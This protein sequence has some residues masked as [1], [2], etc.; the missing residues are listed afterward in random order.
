MYG[1]TTR[2]TDDAT[3]KFPDY[4]KLIEEIVNMSLE[5]SQNGCFILRVQGK[6]KCI[7]P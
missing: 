1:A 7:G 3:G 6:L 2:T 5:A 4:F